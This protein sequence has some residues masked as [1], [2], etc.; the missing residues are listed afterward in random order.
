MD[1][2]CYLDGRI[3]PLEEARIHPLD[4]GFVFGDA[5]YETV[6]VVA[7]VPL[8][9][10]PHL[11]RLARG[12][13]EA[14]IPVPEALARRCF[15]LIAACG[16]DTGSLYIQVSRGAAPRLHFPPPG[17][18][19]TVFILPAEHGFDPPASRRLKLLAVP[20]WRW[21]R[22]YIKSTSLMAT[23]L[24][25]LAAQEA[26]ADE[27]VFVGEGGRVRE[28]GS[29]NFFV[30]RRGALE[31]CP[32]DGRILEGVTRSRLLELA[33]REGFRIRE[34]APSLEEQ[35]Q[36][37]EAFVSGTLTGVQGVVSL[38]GEAV[39][40]GR[41]GPWTRRLAELFAAYEEEQAAAASS[42]EEHS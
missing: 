24:A 23:V 36:W 11:E 3:Q 14:H 15:E 26:G 22:C 13:D 32:L 10:E 31:T 28:G 8:H 16:L 34:R 29:T 5:L 4:R 21:Q 37:D 1:A 27:V 41:V 17:M 39:A 40:G 25:K 7:G 19:P 12:L 2:L 30:R 9:L 6:K 35:E 38:D 42:L 20:D 33:R 18:K